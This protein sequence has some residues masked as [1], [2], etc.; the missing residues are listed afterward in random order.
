MTYLAAVVTVEEN[1]DTE[2]AVQLENFV[3]VCSK[4]QWDETGELCDKLPAEFI[5]EMGQN[6]LFET[7][8]CVFEF[9]GGHRLYKHGSADNVR[10]FLH[11]LGFEYDSSFNAFAQRVFEDGELV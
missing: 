9:R 11:R 5:D 3:V 6:G 2:G 7:T 4:K 1:H 10:G 8:N